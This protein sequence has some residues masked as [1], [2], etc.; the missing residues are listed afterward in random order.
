M[1]VV[2]ARRCWYLRRCKASLMANYLSADWPSKRT[3]FKD[4]RFLVVDLET[5][6]LDVREGEIASIGWVAIEQGVIQLSSAEYYPIQLEDEVGQSAVF[7][8]LHDD[9]L[10]N[11]AKITAVFER[12]LSV[13]AGSVLVF[14]FSSLDMAFL[15]NL[16]RKLF[17]VPL[18]SPMVDTLLLEKKKYLRHAEVIESGALRLFSCRERYNLPVYSAHNALNDAIATAELLLAHVADRGGRTSLSSLI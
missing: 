3:Q 11:A 7:H 5:T 12:F 6:S 4:V 10:S 16:S 18:I 8:H 13:A 14:H 15:N 9:T 2:N 17:S 1:L